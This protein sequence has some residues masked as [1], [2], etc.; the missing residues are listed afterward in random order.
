MVNPVPRPRADPEAGLLP[1]DGVLDGRL[2]AREHGVL[3]RRKRHVIFGYIAVFAC[4]IACLAYLGLASKDFRE[5]ASPTVGGNDR[6][7]FGDEELST[8]DILSMGCVTGHVNRL[9][10]IAD[11]L[12]LAHARLFASFARFCS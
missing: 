8:K 5:R 9:R 6:Q 11:R 12:R 2:L 4:I 10:Q 7:A 3:K 1:T